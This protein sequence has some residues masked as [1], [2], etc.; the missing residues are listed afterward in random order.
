MIRS[1]PVL[2]RL[3]QV[4]WL[5]GETLPQTSKRRALIKSMVPLTESMLPT[6]NFDGDQS[7]FFALLSSKNAYFLPS[8][9]G[10]KKHIRRLTLQLAGLR[11]G[12]LKTFLAF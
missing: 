7:I 10:E 1:F 12:A 6:R 3:G 11:F 4:A 5:S 8:R 2:S 9:D